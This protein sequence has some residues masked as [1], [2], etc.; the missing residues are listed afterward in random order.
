MGIRAPEPWIFFVTVRMNGFKPVPL[1]S[2]G[3]EKAHMISFLAGPSIVPA[4]SNTNLGNAGVSTRDLF[5]RD[6]EPVDLD[7]V[8]VPAD[9][10][11][12]MKDVKVRDIPAIIAHPQKS[13][14]ANT[15]CVSCHTETTRRMQL[16]IPYGES[17]FEF[18][19]GT[20]NLDD[21]LLARGND[22]Q[23]NWNL[24]NFGWFPQDVFQSLQPIATA[25]HRT[26]NEA[27]DSAEFINQRYFQL[28]PP[29]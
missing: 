8:V 20:S 10:S 27:A 4:P 5:P 14:V 28:P 16:G 25:T 3:R 19:G 21:S 6:G 29:Q 24:R 7:R 23:I 13:S 26:A 1:K 17:R 18:G 12:D 9:Q 11:P 2:L 15:D 22:L